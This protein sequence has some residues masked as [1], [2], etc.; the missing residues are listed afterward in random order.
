MNKKG[1]V[2]ICISLGVVIIIVILISV[3]LIYFQ[4]NVLISEIRQELYYELQ[5]GM[6]AIEKDELALNSYLIDNKKLTE[7][8]NNWIQTSG[9][10]KLN[11]I[12]I[13]IKEITTNNKNKKATFKVKLTVTFK[14]IINIKQVASI[15]ITNDIDLSLL[16]LN[17]NR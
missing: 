13:K 15:D 6:L 2:N 1:F 14:P 3:F 7:Q 10:S 9:K 4:V 17:E 11:V 8:I 12:D 5:N 16:K